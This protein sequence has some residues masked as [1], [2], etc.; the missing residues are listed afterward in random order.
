[1]NKKKSAVRKPIR[2]KSYLN[3]NGSLSYKYYDI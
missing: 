1:M 2:G 3:L